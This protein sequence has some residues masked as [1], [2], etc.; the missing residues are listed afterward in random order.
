MKTAYIESNVIKAML[1][2]LRVHFGGELTKELKE[3]TLEIN[4]DLG[5]GIIKGMSLKGGI[6]YLEFDMIFYHDLVLAINTPEKNPIYF[7]YC[8]KG[9]LTHS[10]GEDGEKR[11]LERYQTGILT[12]QN[13]NENV[14]YFKKDEE[15]KTTLITVQTGK[16]G[17]IPGANGLK[18]MLRETFI[19]ENPSGNFIYVGS[20][21]LKI[22]EKIEQLNAISQ[23]G[24]VRSLL[25]QGLVH[26]IL[27]LEIQQHKDD[28]KNDNLQTGSLTRRDMDTIQ[29]VS[30]F[31]NENSESQITISQLYSQFGLSPSKLQEGFKLMHG[32]TVT[33]YIREVRIKKAEELIK[34]TDM[35]ISE[36]VYTIGLTSRSYFSKIFKEK[37]NCSPKDYKFAQR[38]VA[39][40]A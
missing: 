20:H 5:K 27:A 6:S 1:E 17:D 35:N 29:E 3:Y 24:I 4:N 8:S 40:S 19:S 18:D 39:M 14:L 23:K 26:V 38:S 15:L 7:T 36:V 31:I 37:Y 16:K 11:Q 33:E 13:H 21:N 2:Q 32:H 22:A 25:I 10:F 34:N 30:Q 12:S 28:L 9:T